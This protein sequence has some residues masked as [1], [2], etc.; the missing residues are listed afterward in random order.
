[1][2]ASRRGVVPGN[3]RKTARPLTAGGV[4]RAHCDAAGRPARWTAVPTRACSKVNPLS[5]PGNRLH[6]SRPAPHGV[7]GPQ[8][9]RPSVKLGV[10]KG[11]F[12]APGALFCC[13]SPSG[14]T[15]SPQSLYRL[16]Q[17]A[18]RRCPLLA[19]ALDLASAGPAQVYSVRPAPGCSILCYDRRAVGLRR[20]LAPG[21]PLR[22]LQSAGFNSRNGACECSSQY[23]AQ[24]T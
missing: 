2:P 11:P 21:E 5:E 19:R 24:E 12:A 6:L 1:M 3:E 16:L 15:G 9:A 20:G 22:R 23:P 17:R 18:R 13:P 10:T 14:R 8:S 4:P 7:C